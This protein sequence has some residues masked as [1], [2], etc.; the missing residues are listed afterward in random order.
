VTLALGVVTFCLY[1]FVLAEYVLHE[2]RVAGSIS[3]N[4]LGWMDWMIFWALV[5]ILC[6]DSF[7]LKRPRADSENIA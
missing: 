6:F 5:Y 1:Y 2:P 3:G 4:A 7:G